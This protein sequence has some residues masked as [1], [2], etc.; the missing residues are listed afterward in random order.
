MSSQIVNISRNKTIC[1][2]CGIIP[3][4]A[5]NGVVLPLQLQSEQETVKNLK[6]GK[7]FYLLLIQ[8]VISCDSFLVQIKS[9]PLDSQLD[10]DIQSVWVS[11]CALL[12]NFINIKRH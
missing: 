5:L 8:C 4:E 11:T 9:R 3:S 12:S 6:P 10:R 1:K 2:F 7:V